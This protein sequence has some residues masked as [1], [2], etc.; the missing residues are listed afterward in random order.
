MKPGN[1]SLHRPASLDEALEVLEA[2]ANDAKVLAGGQSL[3]PVM[4]FRLATPAVVVDLNRITDLSGIRIE[5]GWVRIGAMTRQ[6][7]LLSDPLVG[8]H[9]PLLALAAGHIGHVQTRNRGT[10]GGSLAHADPS[11]EIPL[12]AATL[13][14]EV[15]LRNRQGE[16]RLRAGE[17]FVDV[18]TTA[19][20]PNELVTEIRFRPAAQGTQVAFHEF[21]RRHGDFAIAAAAAQSAPGEGICAGLGGVDRTPVSCFRSLRTDRAGIDGVV[22]DAVARV[23]PQSD[24]TA[25]AAYRRKLAAAALSRCLEELVLR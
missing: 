20:E 19:L 5:D 8:S 6:K 9:V 16:R 24:T 21:A 15:T 11:A 17:F 14:A 7:E 3:V 12:V 22:A 1:F 25:S 23:E 4:N 10:V 13:D 18:L 2:H